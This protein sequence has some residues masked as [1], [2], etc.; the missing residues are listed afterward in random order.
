MT[1]LDYYKWFVDWLGQ[2]G[3]VTKDDIAAFDQHIRETKKRKEAEEW[4]KENFKGCF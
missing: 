3:R 4:V 2:Q 1:E